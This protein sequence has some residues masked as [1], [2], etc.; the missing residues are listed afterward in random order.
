MACVKTL[1]LKE[2]QIKGVLSSLKNEGD[3]NMLAV[4]SILMKGT[5]I[6]DVLNTIKIKDVYTES[7]EVRDDIMFFEVKTGK[8]RIIEV[9]GELLRLSL[10]MVYKMISKKDRNLSLFYSR[11]GRF[12]NTPMSTITVNRNLKKFIGEFDIEAISSHAIR[13]TA[14]RLL[15]EKGVNIT[16][17]SELLNHSNTKVTAKYICVNTLDVKNALSLLEY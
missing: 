17:I 15:Y 14:S 3:F 7:G 2:Y 6:S 12:S 10:E 5:R 1:P 9:N 4:V 8:E 13:K 16:T 11:K